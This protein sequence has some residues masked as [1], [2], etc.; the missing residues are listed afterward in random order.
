GETSGV[1]MHGHLGENEADLTAILDPH[2]TWCRINFSI[3]AVEP[4]TYSHL[5][6]CWELVPIWDSAEI[7]WPEIL[8]SGSD[9]A[10]NPAAFFQLGPLFAALVPDLEEGDYRYLRLLCPTAKLGFEYGI[11]ADQPVIADCQSTLRFAYTICLDGNAIPNYGY[12]QIIRRL[13]ACEALKVMPLCNTPGSATGTM[14][15]LPHV[16]PRTSWQ[17]FV[18]EGSVTQIA[19][20]TS[21]LLFREGA[22]DWQSLEEG[23]RWLDRL[24]LHQHLCEVPGG[25]LLGSFGIGHEWSVVAPWMPVLLLQAFRLTGI[26]EYAHRAIVAV[27]ALPLEIR[28]TVLQHLRATLGDILLNADSGRFVLLNDIDDFYADITPETIHISV[29]PPANCAPVQLVVDGV[30][31]SYRL[32]VNNDDLGEIPTCVLRAGIELPLF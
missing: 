26:T 32:I 28:L 24:C 3:T 7:R 31:E 12:Q 14:T 17:P 5:T 18:D 15:A 2:G 29:Q 19:A 22:D 8:V 10:W 4:L 11:V 13:G 20:Q 21:H 23:L 16:L 27:N 1:H 25:Q 30:Q 9:L 6:H